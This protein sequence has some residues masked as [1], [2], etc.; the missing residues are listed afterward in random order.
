[1]KFILS[2]NDRILTLIDG[3]RTEKGQLQKSLTKKLEYYNFLPKQVKAKWNGVI[4][5]FHQDKYV[6]SGLWMELR[7]IAKK[8]RYNI[9]IEGLR[10]L[11]YDLDFDEFQEWVDNKFEGATNKKGQIF[12][13]RDYQVHSAYKIIKHKLSISELATSAGKSLIIYLVFSYL[14]EKGL[15]KRC[16]MIVP[17]INLVIQAFE[18]FHEYN[19]FLKEENRTPLEIK[20]IHGGESKEYTSDQNIFVGTFQSLVKFS[21]NFLSAFDTVCCDETHKVKAKSIQ[22]ILGRCHSANR[23]FGLTGTVP[24]AGTL[25]WLTLQA[26]LGPLITEIKAKE[27]QDKG[28]I[29]K[30]HINVIEIHHPEKIKESF[31][32]IASTIE[33]KAKLLRMEQDTIIQNKK[34]IEIIKRVIDKCDGNQLVLFHRTSYGKDLYKYIKENTNKKVYYIDGSIDKN[35]RN[36]IKHL[37]EE[38]TDK[39]LVASYGTFSTGISVKNLHYLHLTESFKSDVI[40]RQSL[41]RGLRLH[42]DKAILQVFDYTDVLRTTKKNL[43]YFHGKARQKIYKEQGF[44][45][46]IKE[47]YL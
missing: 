45:Y 11:F 16:L 9:E 26:Y 36:E 46:K 3:D 7:D 15:T 32:D 12:E 29:S 30:L 14:L 27:L 41:G 2:H 25:D 37:M 38:G 10:N 39:V 6:P 18:D 21:D 17:T 24:K 8:Y 1:M 4:S 20:Q 23:R 5:Y 43:V 40:I 42:D 35:T 47:I 28:H 22:D 19:S 31:D 13:P 33:D 34:R 44:P